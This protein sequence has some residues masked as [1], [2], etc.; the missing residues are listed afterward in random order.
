MTAQTFTQYLNE[1]RVKMA[2]DLLKGGKMKISQVCYHCGFNDLP[3][4]DRKFK[5]LTGVSPNEYRA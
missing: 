1:Y 4:F 3:Y 2:M 5:Q